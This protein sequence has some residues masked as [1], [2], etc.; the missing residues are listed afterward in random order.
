MYI[1]VSFLITAVLIYLGLG[2]L[3]G[4]LAA[5]GEA[6]AKPKG[7]CTPGWPTEEIERIEKERRG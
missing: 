6:C 3:G 5:I 1:S 7:I 4:I 2:L